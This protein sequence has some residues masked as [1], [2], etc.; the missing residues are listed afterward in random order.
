MLVQCSSI[1]DKIMREEC[2][3]SWLCKGKKLQYLNEN[4][5]DY[6]FYFNSIYNIKKEKHK[7]KENDKKIMCKFSFFPKYI[8]LYEE[9][10]DKNKFL[11]DIK[12]H[13]DNKISQYC[14]NSKIDKTLLLTNLRFIIN[15]DYFYEQLG[16]IIIYVPLKYFTINFSD[17]TF[18]VKPIF[19]FI[20]T[21]INHKL[22]EKE[23]KDYFEKGLYKINTIEADNVKGYYFEAYVKFALKNL[24][25]PENKNYELVMLEDISSMEKIINDND[26][27]FEDEERNNSE[28]NLDSI[29]LLNNEEDK[30]NEL[31]F[32]NIDILE[33]EEDKNNKFHFDSIDILEK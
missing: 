21:I 24:I 14:V 17:N 7:L 9:K 18:T 10:E 27:L 8:K 33:K 20:K 13:I 11:E 6:Y 22:E 1:N 26:E 25:F 31:H 12:N 16:E 29:N 30:N 5:Q 23:C 15:N 3:K 2:I 4:N 28:L 19:P 32:D